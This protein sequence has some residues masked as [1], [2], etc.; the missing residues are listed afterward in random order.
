MDELKEAV[1]QDNVEYAEEIMLNRLRILPNDSE[2]WL[3][4]GLIELQYPFEDYDRALEY[5]DKS[6]S[7]FPNYFEAICIKLY[8]TN[9]YYNEIDN[10]LLDRAIEFNYG[11][12][13]KS[14]LYYIKS[15]LYRNNKNIDDEILMLNRSV[16]LCPKFVYPFKRLGDIFKN[17]N[18]SLSKSNYLKAKSNIIEVF[19]RDSFDDFTVPSLYIDEYITGV[20][21][22]SAN[23]EFIEMKCLE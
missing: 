8:L 18:D 17:E 3:K 1:L 21:L 6:I 20:R 2:L 5:I 13:Q 15:W 14:V 9:F 7:E 23:A 19:L 16:E 11:T 10:V 4:L 12:S 22:S